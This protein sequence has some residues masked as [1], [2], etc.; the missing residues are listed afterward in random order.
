[1]RYLRISVWML[2]MIGL[3]SGGA[4]SPWA[5]VPELIRVVDEKR[6]ELSQ[7]FKKYI[8]LSDDQIRAIRNGQ[9][10]AKILDSPTADEVFVFGAVYVRSTPNSTGTRSTLN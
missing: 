10:V 2:L 7:F 1:M 4:S 8:G 9:S 5:R 6:D 3:L